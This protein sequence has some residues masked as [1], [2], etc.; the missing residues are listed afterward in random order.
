MDSLLVSEGIQCNQRHLPAVLARMSPWSSSLSS[1]GDT[2]TMLYFLASC[3]QTCQS[4]RM[5]SNTW[6][7]TDNF[8][9]GY[10]GHSL[11]N[12]LFDCT[13]ELDDLFQN[14]IHFYVLEVNVITQLLLS[15][16][17]TTIYCCYIH[18]A[19]SGDIQYQ[20][21]C[22]CI[23]TKP[24]VDTILAIYRPL[25]KTWCWAHFL[26]TQQ[27][28]SMASF[29]VCR[30]QTASLR[31]FTNSSNIWKTVCVLYVLTVGC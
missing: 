2:I 28:H 24:K 18:M 20:P 10:I 22:L 21:S 16:D 15:Y 5:T 4:P 6:V 27:I 30:R 1:I 12:P 13:L 11:T 29:L 7:W 17:R 8:C 19:Y 3:R 23:A 26:L 25:A 9:Y 31:I 14:C